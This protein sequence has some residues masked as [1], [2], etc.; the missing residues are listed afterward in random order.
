MAIGRQVQ[1]RYGTEVLNLNDSTYILQAEGGWQSAGT[2][3]ALRVLV[4]A[5]T[6]TEMERRVTVVRQALAR[7]AAYQERMAGD[8]VEIWTKTCDTLTP[9]AELGA[10][11]V[12]KRV[13]AGRVEV[14]HIA[15][16]A[17]VPHAILTIVLSVDELWQRALPQPALEC[18]AGVSNL[19]SL[20]SGGLWTVGAVALS[21]R[22]LRWT[23]STGLTA[24]FFW[25]YGSSCS[26][27]I[28]MIRLSAAMR[29]YWGPSASRLYILDNAATPAETAVL[30][31]TNGRTYEVVVRWGY[32]SMSVF[33]DGSKL[34]NHAGTISWP[35][36]P[37][38]YRV[39]ETDELSGSQQFLSVQVWPTA[40]TD[41]EVASLASAGQPAPELAWYEP[42][43][44]S[45]ATNARYVLHNGPGEAPAA[46]RLLVAPPSQTQAQVRLA[47][48]P[49]RR[50]GIWKMECESGTLGT[51]TAAN[52]NAAASGGSQARHT[53]AG[54]SWATRVTTVAAATPSMLA[55]MQGEYRLYLAGYD[56]AAA[57]Q[58]NQLRWR[59]VVSGVAGD[60]SETRAFSAV[61]KRLLLDLGTLTLPPGNWPQETIDATTNVVTGSS[62]VAI[63]LQARN[64][65]GSGGGTLDMDALYLAPAEAEGQALAPIGS[66]TPLALDWTHDPPASVVVRDMRSLEFGGWGAYTGDDVELTPSAGGV[67][68][69]LQALWLRDAADEFY[70]NDE[71]AVQLYYSSRWRV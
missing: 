63:E 46:L 56:S 67:A 71:A 55:A 64:T 12:L 11:W 10:T 16:V 33:V 48:R 25:T 50:P 6:M 60:W 42:P 68:G 30:S 26:A 49:L 62:F 66:S 31:L 19:S 37:E 14:D 27:Q 36:N 8:P 7:A 1:L 40:L 4:K 45:K 54:T 2:A 53:P 32:N 43:T 44:D 29:C 59:L 24:R 65:T 21:A 38:T 9:V 70:P 51:N 23:S 28:N 61:G 39:I 52:S 35:S 34:A 17:A 41:T 15:G 13:R 58:I 5:S 18:S 57:I 22:R 3:L 47:Q 20:S 69:V